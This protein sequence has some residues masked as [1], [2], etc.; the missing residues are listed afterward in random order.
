VFSAP[1]I[2]GTGLAMIPAGIYLILIVLR[3]ALEDNTLRQEL[4]GYAEYAK[5]VK[6][7]LLPGFW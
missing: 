7:R 3:T 5:I 6:Y 1:L 4:T 2:L